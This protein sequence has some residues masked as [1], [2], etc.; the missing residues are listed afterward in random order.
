[1]PF[2]RAFDGHLVAGSGFVG[3]SQVGG[4]ACYS[5]LLEEG[6]ELDEILP[7]L[8]TFA[9]EHA[10]LDERLFDASCACERKL[11]NKWLLSNCD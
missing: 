9:D 1:M 5:A 7:E 11:M 10:A 3:G 4:L 8:E 2:H 6:D